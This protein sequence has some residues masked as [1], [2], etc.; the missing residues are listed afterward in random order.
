MIDLIYI[1]MKG[2][3]VIVG[4]D[5]LAT[6]NAMLDCARKLVS[7]PLSLT[8]TSSI[9]QLRF[10]SVVQAQK[11]I[12]QGCDAYIVVC[13]AISVYDGGIE[14]IGVVSEFLKVFSEEMSGLPLE[15]EVEFSIDLVPGIKPISKAPYWISPSELN[16]LKKQIKDW[17][18]K[19][20]IRPSVSP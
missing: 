6:N 20:F 5:F 7:L 10:L 13:V 16:E 8:R 3:D 14:K 11:L 15:R 4:M 19:R 12:K 1:L 17:F 9:E 2:I 18:D